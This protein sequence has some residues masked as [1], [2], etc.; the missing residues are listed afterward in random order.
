MRNKILIPAV[1]LTALAVFFSFRYMGGTG[2]EGNETENK[3][4]LNTVMAVLEQGHFAPRPIDDAFSQSVFDKTLE[5]LDYEKKFFLQSDVDALTTYRNKID[6]EIKDNSLEFFNTVNNTFIERV[7][8]AEK[9]YKE[10]LQQPFSFDGNEEIELDSKKISFAKDEPALRTRWERYLKYRVLAKYEDLK[11]AD[12]KKVKDSA[13][14]KAKD[15]AAL[16][17]EARES[18]TKVQDRYFKR[19]KKLNDNDRFALFMN[20]ITGSEDPHTDF[21]PPEDK[22]R[23]DEMMSGSFIGIGASLQQTEDGK[24]KVAAIITGSPS[25]KQGHLKAEDVIVKVAQGDQAPVDVEGMETDDVVKLIRGPKDTEVRLTV[26]HADGTTEVVPI[27]RGKVD[28]EDTFAKSAIIENK[29]KKIGYIYLPEFYA[30]FNG[31]GSGHSSGKDVANEVIKLKAEQVDGIVLDLRNNGGGSLSDVV[32]MA[33]IFI[34]KGPVVQVRASGNQSVTL[35]S[36][37][38][39]PLYTGPLAI[40]VN[41]G[42][43]SASE[44][45]AAAMQDYGR[46]VIIGTNTFGKGTVQKLVSLDQFVN[47]SMRDQIIAA[48]NKAK[49]G[50]AQYD[51]IGSLKL[52]IQKFYRVDGGSTQLKGVA[53]DIIL[54]DAYEQLDNIGE[55][56]DKAALPWDKINAADYKLWDSPPAIASLK[57]GSQKRVEANETFKI[58]KQTGERLKLQQDNNI[59]PLNEAKFV[60]KQKESEALSKKLE[61]LDK[62]SSPINVTNLRSDMA[63]VNIDTTSKAKNA[64]WLKALKKDVYISETANVLHEWI[65]SSARVVRM[66]P[67]MTK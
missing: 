14:Y 9:Y 10:I 24:I 29:G 66:S 59:V 3:T 41:N 38:T 27:I 45:M 40:M 42:S 7:N 49:G 55:R 1:I 8:G 28:M 60:A 35:K 63:K 31:N 57:T 2:E 15:F 6:D 52:T 64:D 61:E 30:D 62:I 4:I 18:I 11:E 34:G 56:R 50:E 13:N 20:S 48:F 67:E 54:P 43:A 39:A 65:S 5:N 21:L 26:K 36:Q 53:P 47:S 58:I 46:A 12:Q 32:D 23:F 19:L 33:G 16:E 17:K 37:N 25:W 51:G 44:I 22:K